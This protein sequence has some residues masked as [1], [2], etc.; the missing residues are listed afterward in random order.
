[1]DVLAKLENGEF[2]AMLPGSTVGEA[3]RLAKRMDSAVA[4]C[5]LP[6]VD[7]GLQI[8]LRNGAAELKPAESAQEL[9]GRARQIANAPAT[10]Q[11]TS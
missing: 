2:V 11:A 8:V 3:T 10:R 1:M 7:R 9:I 5:I 4:N 6:V